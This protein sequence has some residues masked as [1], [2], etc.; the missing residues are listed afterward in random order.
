MPSVQAMH[1][2]QAPKLHGQTP[3]RSTCFSVKGSVWLGEATL[4]SS[5]SPWRVYA[6]PT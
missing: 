3:R 2:R 6:V 1:T 4:L 5:P